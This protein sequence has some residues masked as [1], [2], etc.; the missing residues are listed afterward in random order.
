[1]ARKK[2]ANTKNQTSRT[3]K[4]VLQSKTVLEDKIIYARA[5]TRV[6][7]MSTMMGA[8]TQVIVNAT[9]AMAS[10]MAEALDGR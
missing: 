2:H 1:M 9:G 8:F 4:A 3:K 10:G 6:I 7:L 5:N